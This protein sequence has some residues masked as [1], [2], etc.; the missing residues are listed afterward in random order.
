MHITGTALWAT[1][2]TLVFA[3]STNVKLDSG[4]IAGKDLPSGIKFWT[5]IPFAKSP[6][7]RFGRPENP[8]PWTDTYKATV[9]KPACMQ[10]F[11]S[12][13]LV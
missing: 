7:E 6:P 12:K 5:G 13:F 1:W 9:R 4:P 11:K 3:D 10:Q 8:A 2:A